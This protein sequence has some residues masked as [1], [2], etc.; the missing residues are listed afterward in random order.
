MKEYDVKES[1]T[2]RYHVCGTDLYVILT[3]SLL[4]LKN[5]RLICQSIDTESLLLVSIP[6]KVQEYD[7][8]MCMG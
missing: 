1:W 8:H 6:N 5:D 7:I 2:K 4:F 3:L